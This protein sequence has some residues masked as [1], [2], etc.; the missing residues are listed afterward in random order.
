[1]LKCFDKKA[2]EQLKKQLKR[3][4]ALPGEGNRHEKTCCTSCRCIRLNLEMQ[5]D[6]LRQA[7]ETTEA[8][9][10]EIYNAFRFGPGWI[11]LHLI[12]KEQFAN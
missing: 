3:S 9:L 4:T 7:Y 12:K 8:A 11:F 5:N 6:E 10:K 2:E 1:M